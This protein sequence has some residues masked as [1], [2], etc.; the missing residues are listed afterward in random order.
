MGSQIT[1]FKA[2]DIRG[3]LNTQLTEE[4]AYRIGYAFAAEL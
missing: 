1:C 3:E 4:V 2:Y